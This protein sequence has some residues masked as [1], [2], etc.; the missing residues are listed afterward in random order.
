MI[1]VVGKYFKSFII[2][3]LK[4]LK[5]TM[6]TELKEGIVNPQIGSINKETEPNISMNQNRKPK[7]RSTQDSQLTLTMEQKMVMKQLDIHIKKK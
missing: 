4:E 5:K 7:N 1:D 6:H 3:I 2:N